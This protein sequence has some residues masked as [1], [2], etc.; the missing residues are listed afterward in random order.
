MPSR[1]AADFAGG[2]STFRPR[3]TGRS[4]LVRQNAISCR[5]ASRSRT[6]APNGAVAANPI[7]AT[8]EPSACGTPGRGSLPQPGHC[9]APCLVRRPVEDEHAVQVVELVLE[10]AS[11]EPLQLQLDVGSLRVLC[12]HLHGRWPLD[13]QEQPLERETAFAVD[14]QLVAAPNEL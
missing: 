8:S 3:P 11:S 12:L 6:P 13:G 14:L 2:G 5:A 1:S 9:F 7:G 10:R 4:G